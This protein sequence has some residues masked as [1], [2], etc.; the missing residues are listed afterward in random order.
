MRL[1][2]KHNTVYICLYHAYLFLVVSGKHRFEQ[3]LIENHYNIRLN[4]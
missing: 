1:C 3:Y 4:I 2:V